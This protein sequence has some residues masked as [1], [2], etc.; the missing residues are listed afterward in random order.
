[1]C[2][3]KESCMVDCSDELQISKERDYL[4]S[5][6]E[7]IHVDTHDA[8][9]ETGVR[10]LSSLE[11]RAQKWL[12]S[13]E[14]GTEREVVLETDGNGNAIDDDYVNRAVEDVQRFRASAPGEYG[15]YSSLSPEPI[16]VIEAWGMNYHAGTILKYLSRYERKGGVESLEKARWFLDR[17]IEI[18]KAK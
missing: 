16:E 4:R 9:T 18:E 3:L 15:Q 12:I 10:A 7:Q 2:Y 11:E 14:D 5:V 17:L 1:M 8:L 13:K 6:V